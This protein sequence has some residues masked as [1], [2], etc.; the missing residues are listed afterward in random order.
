MN[1]YISNRITYEVVKYEDIIDPE[2]VSKGYP[3]WLSKGFSNGMLQY[4]FISEMESNVLRVYTPYSVTSAVIGDYLYR[5]LDSYIHVCKGN[6]FP[7]MFTAME[8]EK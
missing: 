5:G 2:D 6:L 1:N 7:L 8:V 3:E 4:E